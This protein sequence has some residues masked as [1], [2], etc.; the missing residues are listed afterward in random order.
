MTEL[1]RPAF[2]RLLFLL[3][4]TFNEPVSDYRLEAYFGALADLLIAD[5]QAAIRRAIAEARFFP[6]PVEIR[7]YATGSLDDNAEL[8][9]AAVR[10]LVQRVGYYNVPGE[11]GQPDWPDDATKRAALEL[12]GGWQ[13]LCE[14]LPASGPELLGFRKTFLA[15]YRA[16]AARVPD[17]VFRL[18]P[19]PLGALES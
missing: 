11:K 9:W 15:T 5:V 16:Y 7:E 1:D 14:N 3:G 19:R 10:R 4:D 8:A 2:G 6:R 13:A 18:G 12:Y 17:P